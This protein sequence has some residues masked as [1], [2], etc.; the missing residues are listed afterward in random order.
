MKY[1]KILLVTSSNFNSFTGT[2]ITLSNLFEGW[3]LD[4]IA[5]VDTDKFNSN[6]NICKLEYKLG[7][8]EQKYV[9][10]LS[11]IKKNNKN[12]K[13]KKETQTNERSSQ[14]K[15]TKYLKQLKL[16]RILNSTIGNYEIFISQ[17]VSKQLLNFVDDFKPDL[18]YFHFSSIGSLRFCKQ[19]VEHCKI[20]YAVHF[21]DDFYHF[22]Y[23]KGILS[24]F[25]K[26][27]WKKEMKEF[28]KNANL[29]MGISEKMS[30]EY[31]KIFN[32]DFY[33]FFNIIDPEKWN[34]IKTP[35]KNCD[36]FEILYAGTINDKNVSSLHDVANTVEEIN[37]AGKKIN[38][39]IYT[40]QPRAES[41]KPHFNKYEKTNIYE[42][43]EGDGIIPLLK[44]SDLLLL[45]IDFTKESMARMKYSMFT[46]IPA[47]MMSGTPVLF[48]GP[49]GIASTEYAREGGWAIVVD[50]NDPKQLM[51]AIKEL[52]NDPELRFSIANKAQIMANEKHSTGVVKKQFHSLL[53]T[54]R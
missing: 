51:V 45:S 25:L 24:P 40:F 17:I 7:D 33:P 11:L 38:Y 35:E 30:Y 22:N 31:S 20:P 8:L 21:M 1:K 27:I 37:I 23:T 49:E 14:A 28:V 50:K 36:N 44:K 10:P 46:K 41:Y 43:P 54:M 34:N 5:I 53:N 18:L 29:R 39:S 32:A 13:P 16:K 15:S 42:V 26:R 12:I 52:I 6:E 48:W 47:Y 3:P 19:I 9:F 4:N 2:G